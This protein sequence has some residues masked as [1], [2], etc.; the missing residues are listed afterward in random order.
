M[1]GKVFGT[2][3]TARRVLTPRNEDDDLTSEDSATSFG[4]I[5]KDSPG[6]GKRIV[7][8]RS[9]TVSAGMQMRSTN[10]DSNI[11]LNRTERK[12]EP[13]NELDPA[14]G[15]SRTQSFDAS[16]LK[17]HEQKSDD[18]TILQSHQ[19]ESRPTSI[20]LNANSVHSGKCHQLETRVS[21]SQLDHDG[22]R[23][24]SPTDSDN[25]L[26]RDEQTNL[27]IRR[28]RVRKPVS[29]GPSK[30][31]AG[32]TS[33]SQ[34]STPARPGSASGAVNRQ[35]RKALPV[36][37]PVSAKPSTAL[38]R[39]AEQKKEEPE[40]KTITAQQ[41]QT[42]GVETN[43][44]GVETNSLQNGGIDSGLNSGDKIE[45]TTVVSSEQQ[46]PTINQASPVKKKTLPVCYN[47]LNEVYISD[48]YLHVYLQSPAW[49][50]HDDELSKVCTNVCRPRY[51]SNSVACFLTA[52]IDVYYPSHIQCI[53][54]VSIGHSGDSK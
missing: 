27:D 30:S 36:P 20:D 43:G 6:A 14:T 31:V 19:D 4:P 24:G 7:R 1:L 3:E 41:S 25:G 8:P 34:R 16:S 29:E 54:Y 26:Y 28:Q 23:H 21:D 39:L 44:N 38:K 33:A 2:P 32:R 17:P 13:E 51:V 46:S 11:K 9:A 12:Q 18:S 35:K 22:I 10:S 52:D 40:L 50:E 15:R 42:D 49:S 48:G 45:A 47:L 5:D 53:I 37:R